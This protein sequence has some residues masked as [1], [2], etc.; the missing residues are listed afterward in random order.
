MMS[1]QRTPP[2]QG[3][4]V[5]YLPLNWIP[6]GTKFLMLSYWET[7]CVR[8][9]LVLACWGAAARTSRQARVSSSGGS[10]FPGRFYGHRSHG[11]DRARPLSD[12]EEIKFQRRVLGVHSSQSIESSISRS[13]RA[14]LRA[15]L[16]C[17]SQL[18]RS[19]GVVAA[20]AR[21]SRCP[22]VCR[23]GDDASILRRVYVYGA[24][25]S[26]TVASRA[27]PFSR[28]FCS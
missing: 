5:L 13:A 16:T 23:K 17:E 14:V 12:A 19:P 24:T 26:D 6:A 10:K 15:Q 11:T 21:R 2:S 25:S 3:V 9:T 7:G 1:E 27:P 20:A 28:G 18:A 8:M 4:V 22:L